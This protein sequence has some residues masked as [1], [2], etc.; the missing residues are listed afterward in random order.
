MLLLPSVLAVALPCCHDHLAIVA[1]TACMPAQI[2][3]AFRSPVGNVCRLGWSIVCCVSG[4]QL[5]T[6]TEGT[7]AVPTHARLQPTHPARWP[8]VRRPWIGA[9]SGLLLI[10]AALSDCAVSW[11][12]PRTYTAWSG[13]T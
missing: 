5:P 2:F 4:V 6:C 10:G 1:R 13:C 8:M 12:R 7:Y 3:Q 11:L 9:F